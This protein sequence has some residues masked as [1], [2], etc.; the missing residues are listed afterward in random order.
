MSAFPWSP[1]GLALG[2]PL[3][4][5]GPSLGGS[6]RL[7]GLLRADTPGLT[8]GCHPPG[9]LGGDWLWGLAALRAGGRPWWEGQGWRRSGG[10]PGQVLPTGRQQSLTLVGQREDPD[11]ARQHQVPCGGVSSPRQLLPTS[12][13]P[14]QVL[15][16]SC[17]AR[18]SPRPASGFNPG[19][20]QITASV[21]GLRARDMLCASFQK[22]V[23]VSYRHQ[24]LL[25]AG[26]QPKPHRL[27]SE[28]A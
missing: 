20:F 7:R 6:Q 28:S 5:P 25:Y 10:V 18:C 23:S 14:E 11:G 22:R 26:Y 2:G 24:A 16:A 9:G 1:A 12:V 4:P 27:P 21:L 15:A 8:A 19:S 3:W 17:L 13:S